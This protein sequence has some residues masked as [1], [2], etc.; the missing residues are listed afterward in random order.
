MDY[1]KLPLRGVRGKGKYTLVDGDYDGEYF[2]RF[3]WYLS[4]NGYAYRRGHGTEPITT[5]L[6]HEVLSWCPKGYVR[7]HINRDRL[8]N[9]SINLRLSTIRQNRTQNRALPKRGGA[10]T[11]RFIGVHQS[12][13]TNKD[14]TIRFY[15][16]W[17]AY[18][19]L[20]YLGSYST[21][22][23]AA[24]AYDDAAIREYGEFA[25]LNFPR[26]A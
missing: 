13:Y 18:F 6:H 3:Q 14:G 20:H 16:R 2:S 24:K 15:N 23:E 5:Y 21:P 8:D 10:R 19:R 12:N 17:Y 1:I 4:N 11:C 26:A 22:E 9:R 7:D 25:V